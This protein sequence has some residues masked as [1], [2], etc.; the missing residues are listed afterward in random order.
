MP[1]APHY[2]DQQYQ[3][4]DRAIT[5][6]GWQQLQAYAMR[7]RTGDHYLGGEN[8]AHYLR[9][10]LAATSQRVVKASL[11]HLEGETAAD[12]EVSPSAREATVK[13][14]NDQMTIPK[15]A[16]GWT[17]QEIKQSGR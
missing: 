9:F 10:E 15:G 4:P 11:I 13:I 8:W 6:H 2:H 14:V 1:P 7:I 12:I 3:D 16:W 5:W 17:L